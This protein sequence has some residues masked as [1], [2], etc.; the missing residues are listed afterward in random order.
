VLALRYTPSLPRYAAARAGLSRRPGAGAL[1]LAELRPPR[2]PGPDWLLVRPRLSGVCGSDQALLGGRA[3]PYLGMLTAGPF[4]P[5]H[6]VV[7]EIAAGERAGR[8]VVLQPALGCSVRGIDPPC[9]QCEDGRVALCEHVTGGELAPGLQT[10]YCRDT[11]G[12]WGELLT[13]HE[14]QLHDV[15]PDLSDEDAVM[16]EPLACALHG[17]ALADPEPGDVVAVI[18]AGAMGLLAVAALRE[19][20]PDL[21]ILCAAKHPA[22]AV[23]ARRLGADLACPAD[24]LT[25]EAARVTG[26]RR[27]VGLQGRE[28]LIGGV[29]RVLDCVGSSVSLQAAVGLARARGR[30][31]MVGMPGELKV[32]L[33]VAWLHELE[34]RGA[35]GYEADFPAAIEL[36]GRLRPG[37]LVAEGWPLR[38]WQT[39]LAE[40]PKA[41]RGGR[42]RTVFDLREEGA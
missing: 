5:G 7:G 37:A 31:V 23:A 39:A 1:G 30:V 6:E 34:L 17:A 21:T 25:L 32:D 33:S 38:R 12:G 11:G 41:A 28:L 15:P 19:R 4:T 16:V 42:V 14:S 29:D 10:G 8:R 3:S 24:R 27:L 36:A 18:G 20:E 35:Y 2:P 40:A 13:A 26:A 22:Q 9:A